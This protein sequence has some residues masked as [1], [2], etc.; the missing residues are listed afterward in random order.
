MSKAEK[1]MR[2]ILQDLQERG[3]QLEVPEKEIHA[4]IRRQV[5]VSKDTISAY[6]QGLQDMGYIQH[7]VGPVYRITAMVSQGQQVETK[8]A[9]EIF[10]EVKEK[11]EKAEAEA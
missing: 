9:E 3:F 8:T 1:N 11:V 7:K 2:K 6:M 10:E 5:G 4:A